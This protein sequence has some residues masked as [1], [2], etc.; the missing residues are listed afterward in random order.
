MEISIFLDIHFD[1]ISE[2]EF[3]YSL[4]IECSLML[5]D[6]LSLSSPFIFPIN[7]S[8]PNEKS[9]V[10]QCLLLFKVRKKSRKEENHFKVMHPQGQAITF[11]KA[12][13]KAEAILLCL[14]VHEMPEKILHHTKLSRKFLNIPRGLELEIKYLP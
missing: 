8:Q 11:I 3:V 5:P 2:I 6:S 1:L 9:F 4:E 12:H 7:R 13:E 14:F 10:G